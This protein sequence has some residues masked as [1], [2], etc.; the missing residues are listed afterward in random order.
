MTSLL[1]D[2]NVRNLEMSRKKRRGFIK[3]AARKKTTHLFTI[4]LTRHQKT[5]MSHDPA[6][7]DCLVTGTHSQCFGIEFPPLYD[8]TMNEYTNIEE[9]QRLSN[10]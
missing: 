7:S 1:S 10:L 8:P 3:L 2:M 4:Y 5:F 9:R 6:D